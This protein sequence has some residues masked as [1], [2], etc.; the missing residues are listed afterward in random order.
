M[1]GSLIHR[2]NCNTHPVSSMSSRPEFLLCLNI[3][4]EGGALVLSLRITAFLELMA[5][6]T[7][8]APDDVRVLLDTF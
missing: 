6:I 2:H 4:E 7:Y 5:Q 8:K 3:E 1:H